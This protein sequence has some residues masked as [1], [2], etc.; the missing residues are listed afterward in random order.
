MSPGTF[1]EHIAGNL[2]AR[3]FRSRRF[4]IRIA[5]CLLL[6]GITGSARA[7]ND[8]DAETLMKS[9]REKFQTART[10]RADIKLQMI[11]RK[12][13]E[14]S[15]AVHTRGSFWAI[16]MARKIGADS[17]SAMKA[18]CDGK[19]LNME[20]FG[21]RSKSRPAYEPDRYSRQLREWCAV[22]FA[23]MSFAFVFEDIDQGDDSFPVVSAVKFTGR[24]KLRGVD[25]VVISY[26]LDYPG[27]KGMTV[28]AW[29]DA[30][31][32]LPIQR[33]TTT[34]QGGLLLEIIGSVAIDK[35]IPDSAFILKP[36]SSDVPESVD[37]DQKPGR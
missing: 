24:E 2:L 25:T 36:P 8:A 21:A 17:P 3:I 27:G 13:L 14:Y 33:Q 4:T 15:G 12:P 5:A 37:K 9:I 29:I 23:P 28:K 26:A 32:K 34:K 7:D 19:T 6:T 18:F 30:A 11:L 35:E 10:L 22:S 1:S 31:T 16:D 20:G